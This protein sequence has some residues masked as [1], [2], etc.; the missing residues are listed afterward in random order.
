MASISKL[1]TRKDGSMYYRISVS[2]GH[3]QTP[4]TTRFNVPDKWSKSKA[5]KEVQKFAAKFENDCQNGKIELRADRKLR[6]EAERK[7]AL[8]L[9][10]FKQYAEGVFLPSKRLSENTISNY[11]MFLNVH[12]YPVIG[13][14]KLPEISSAIIRKLLLDFQKTRHK[15]QSCIKLYNIMNGVFKMAVMDDS[16]DYSPMN[17]VERPK[18]DK[19]DLVDEKNKSFTSEELQYIIKCIKNEPIEWQTY[20]MLSMYTG[21]RRGEAVGLRW[22]DIDFYKGTIT[23]Q[24][25]VQYTKEKGVYETTPKNGKARVISI[26]SDLINLLY[27]LREKQS[28]ICISRYVFSKDDTPEVMN[29][30]TP[31]E[32]FHRFGQRYGIKGLHPHKLRHSF[33]SVAIT[34]GAD[35]V[36]VSEILGHSDTAVTL[37]MYAHAN[38]E[39][40]KKTISIFEEA[41][42]A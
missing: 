37:R 35:I 3:G 2:R 5:E 34:N 6:E 15:H 10:T 20:F 16:I 30:Q 42:K 19:E 29:P 11:R 27:A 13:D 31:T 28:S 4:F 32:H 40:K 17:K 18:P 39:S 7:E 12:I 21:I 33:A 41:I 1:M 25:N 26:S 22:Q 14:M 24:N 8:K 9:E 23:I 36:S 38:E